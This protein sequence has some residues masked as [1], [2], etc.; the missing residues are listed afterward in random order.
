MS[1]TQRDR[2]RISE[3]LTRSRSLALVL[4][5][6]LSAAWARPDEARGYATGAGQV[7][8]AGTWLSSGGE[9]VRLT[10]KGSSISSKFVRESEAKCPYGSQRMY[11]VKGEL[12]ASSFKGTMERCTHDRTLIKDCHLTD[13]YKVKF[14]ARATK[15]SISGTFHFEYYVWDGVKNGHRVHCRREPGKEGEAAF[16]LVRH[17]ELKITSLKLYDR[18]LH[19]DANHPEYTPL[20]YLSVSPHGYPCVHESFTGDTCVWGTI[21]IRGDKQDELTNL[22]LQVLDGDTVLAEALLGSDAQHKLLHKPFG[23]AQKLE[24]TSKELLFRLASGQTGSIDQN[25]DGTLTLRAKAVAADSQQTEKVASVG[26]TVQKLV[27]Y[28][29]DNRYGPPDSDQGGDAWVRPSV[30]AVLEH[31]AFGHCYGDM[32]NMNG[33]H[34]TPHQTHQDGIDVDVT[35]DSPSPCAAGGSFSSASAADAQR[36]IDDLNDPMAASIIRVYATFQYANSD[37]FW[38]VIKNVTLADGRRA[39]RVIRSVAGH[40][41]H[42]HWR[43]V[44]ENTP[45][46]CPGDAGVPP[47]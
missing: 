19:P 25:H 34:F 43:F 41:N 12:K 45:G 29:G 24:I 42:F 21:T 8:V 18:D 17:G 39:C 46:Q 33:G 1:C 26:G 27:L 13:P 47:S 15:N 5:I 7:N 4:A 31:F 32:S 40:T 38:S 3:V 14:Q 6:I 30:E 35:F 28:T 16:S 9:L 11:L 20:K 22:V 36:I 2:E 10:Q 37:P 23:A 44:T